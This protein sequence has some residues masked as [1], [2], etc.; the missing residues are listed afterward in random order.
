[1]NPRLPVSFI[2]GS[3]ADPYKPSMRLLLTIIVAAFMAAGTA[4]PTLAQSSHNCARAALASGRVLPLGSILARVRARVPGR[5]VGVRLYGCPRGPFVYRLRMLTAGGRIAI[6]TANART[7]RII[8]V[9]G[10]VGA[11]GRRPVYRR[12]YTRRTPAGNRRR[13]WFRRRR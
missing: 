4:Q 9:R 1:M 7:G 13:P 10:G 5:M 2:R 12:P 11:R 6:V 3:S 8:A